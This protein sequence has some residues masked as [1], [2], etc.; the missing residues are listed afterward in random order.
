MSV[1]SNGK[2]VAFIAQG[3]VFVT[4]VEGGVTK[5]ITQ[6][7]ENEANVSFSPDG[8]TLVYASERDGLWRIFKA[9][10][11]RE[12]EPYFYASTLVTETA[13]I[14]NEH[15]NSQPLFSPDG[16]EIAFVEDRHTV[17]IF[18]L[19]SEE[20]RTILTSDEVF[21]NRV[22]GQYFQWNP[23]GEW[24]LFDYSIP[25]FSPGEVGLVKADGNTATYHQLE[26][27]NADSTTSDRVCD[28][29][30]LCLSAR[31]C[32]WRAETDHVGSAGDRHRGGLGYG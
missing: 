12:E 16:T 11:T 22:G 5:Q 6:T 31:V 20:S 15:E 23:D 26:M 7:P 18:N 4:S 14:D 8:N 13:L 1:S 24:L 17:R 19:E 30:C 3:E 2:E 27:T 9:E 25:G 10:R 29:L 21:S 32:R 28:H